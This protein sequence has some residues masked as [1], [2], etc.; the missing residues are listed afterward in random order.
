MEDVDLDIERVSQ[1][2]VEA[3]ALIGKTIATAESCTAGMVSS[4]LADVPGASKVLR[5]G[6]VTYCDEIK[7]RVLGVPEAILARY[8]AV[9]DMTAKEMALASRDLFQSDVA[10]SLT[11]YAGPGGGS[12]SDPVGTVYIGLAMPSSL[13]V[14]RCYFEGTRTSVRKKAALRALELLFGAAK[15]L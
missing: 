5:G 12:A 3:Y 8:T 7:H 11:G 10:V 1:K 14:E 9:S 13:L 4:V 6:A 15:S 2:V